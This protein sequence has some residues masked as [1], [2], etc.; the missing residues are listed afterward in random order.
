MEEDPLKIWQHV[1]GASSHFPIAMGLTAF[2]IHV[3]PLKVLHSHRD[4]FVRVAV[5]I[6][7]LAS[8]PAV[9]SGLSADLGWFGVEPWV[10]NRILP[11]RNAAL[12]GS[13]LLIILTILQIWVKAIPKWVI[14]LFLLATTLAIGYAG[15]MGGYVSRGY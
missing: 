10:A 3:V 13:A 5:L 1:H 11:H 2:I 9:L 8:I 12:C 4:S 6:G 15:F 14:T 7:A